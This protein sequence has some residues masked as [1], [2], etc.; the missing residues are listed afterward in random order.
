MSVKGRGI[1]LNLIFLKHGCLLNLELAHLLVPKA[2]GT[3]I[4]PLS[5]EIASFFFFKWCWRLSPGPSAFTAPSLPAV[6]VS[7]PVCGLMPTSLRSP[8]TVLFK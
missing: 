1:L 4:P 8:E 6:P 2:R 5:T 3:L 7:L